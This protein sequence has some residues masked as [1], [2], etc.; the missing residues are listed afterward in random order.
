MS[1]TRFISG[2][3]FEDRRLIR[4][5]GQPVIAQHG[6]LRELLTA[7]APR[8]ADLFAEPVLDSRDSAPPTRVSWY[9]PA[10]EDPR[11]LAGLPPAQR[12]AAE[13][14]L[15]AGLAELMALRNEPVLG[16]LLCAALVIPQTEDVLWTGTAPLI[17]N[18]GIA[19]ASVGEDR[20][21]LAKQF[22]ATLGP[23]APPGTNPW[24]RP[25][26]AAPVTPPPIAAGLPGGRI[27]GRPGGPIGAPPGVPVGVPVGGAGAPP[28]PPPPPGERFVVMPPGSGPPWWTGIGAVAAAI[29]IVLL[30][31]VVSLAAG[32][33]WGWTRLVEEMQANASPVPDQSVDLELRR[34]QEGI[35]DG[36]RH[37]IATL[38]QTL[39]G[40][41]ICAA[42]AGPMPATPTVPG[43]PGQAPGGGAQGGGAQ[44]RPVEPQVL[45]PPPDA[46]PVQREP[47]RAG[48][49]PQQTN[50]ANLL[51]ASVVMVIGESHQPNGQQG[52]TMGSGFAIGPDRIVTNRHVVEHVTAGKLFV[53][54]AKLGQ[55]VE[56]QVVAMT[57][58]SDIGQP[59]FA[60]LK[61]GEGQ[62]QPL[63]LS[64]GADRLASVVAV[65]YPGFA[66]ETADDFNRL[67]HGGAG[68]MPAPIFTTGEISALQQ[69][70]GSDVVVH[71][72]AINRGN[73]GGPLS[74]RCGRVVGVNTFIRTDQEVAY[75]IDYALPT[76]SLVAF[77]SANG[78]TPRTVDT[79]CQ[80]A[81][82][83]AAGPAQSPMPPQAS[84]APGNAPATP[85]PATPAPA[86]P[87]LA[88]S[89]P[90]A[91]APGGAH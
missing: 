44:S 14:A 60:L 51:E 36:L 33:Y 66:M 89:T 82:P 25:P 2:S 56:A 5:D 68:T 58:N 22:D 19:P 83:L 63:I 20:E 47:D 35:N 28:P 80:P 59:D 67:M 9:G 12:A 18:W 27:G 42:A 41:D 11:P 71:T 52:L 40:G 48:D 29:A 70:H 50:L 6:R 57:Q 30:V 72:A 76:A 1:G 38:E 88:P 79:P 86:T 24:V 81:P 64:R 54:N 37:R 69:M 78:V 45:P 4:V 74:D 34:V 85:P 73:S 13:T 8:F 61:I 87:A 17:V 90:P 55:P 3:N 21:S 23:Y 84:N 16:A 75:R 43:Q 10:G 91:A 39:Q 7:R 31:C 53:A 46:Q 26:V 15:R 65:G 62:L 49:P 77:L 32:Y